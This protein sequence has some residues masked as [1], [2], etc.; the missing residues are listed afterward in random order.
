MADFTA[1]ELPAELVAAMSP[2]AVAAGLPHLLANIFMGCRVIGASLRSCSFSSDVAGST[3][4]F[5]D[6]QLDVDLKTDAVLFDALRASGLVEVASSEEVPTAVPCGGSGY[7]VAFDPLDGSSVV[8]A[9]F[10]VGTILGVWPGPSL[11]N[12]TGREQCASLVVMYGPRVTAALALNTTATADGRAISMEL[13]MHEEGWVVS[14]PRF[15]IAPQGRVFAP[16]NLRAT[17]DNA[18]YKR[19][20]DFWIDSQYTLRYSGGLVPDIYHILIK[21][22]GVLSNVASPSTKAKLRLLY[23]CAPIALIIESAGGSSCVSPSEVGESLAPVSLLDVPVTT[24]DRRVGVC[25]GSTEEVE[26]FKEYLFST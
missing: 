14:V 8:D 22:K 11:L 21:G 26:R 15:Q 3:N 5:G 25:Y 1:R 17:K 10:A 13:T 6:N 12:R 9:N 7:C 19:L 16:G 24:L 23:E 2:E 18:G 4:D 20:V